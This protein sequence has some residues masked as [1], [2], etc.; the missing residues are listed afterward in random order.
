MSSSASIEAELTSTSISPSN[1]ARL[2]GSAAR[3]CATLTTRYTCCAE[4]LKRSASS[5]WLSP[6]NA[7]KISPGRSW[8]CGA[9]SILI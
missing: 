1:A 4:V 5:L 9:R 8:G 7:A 6:V 3:A 2:A